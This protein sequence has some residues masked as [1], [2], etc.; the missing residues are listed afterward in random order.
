V[1]SSADALTE[2]PAWRISARQASNPAQQ[3]VEKKVPI[4]SEPTPTLLTAEQIEALLRAARD[5]LPAVRSDVLSDEPLG[6]GDVQHLRNTSFGEAAFAETGWPE[7]ALPADELLR[8]AEQQLADAMSTHG[9]F[10]EAAPTAGKAFPFASFDPAPATGAA[11][12]L[13]LEALGDIELDV[14]LE[15]GRAEVTIEELLQLREGSVV[16]LDKAAG[17]PIDILANGR[18]VARGEVIV[19]DDKFGVRIC[20]V[21]SQ[22]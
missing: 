13:S 1:E 15:L 5:R 22:R 3:S 12:G 9:D 14:T 4:V 8:Q 6:P 10:H 18:L 7:N 17:D 2:P 21:I 16:P 19:V 20:E 11:S